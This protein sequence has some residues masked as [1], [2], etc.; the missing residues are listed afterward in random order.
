M[1]IRSDF[2]VLLN[3]LRT[4]IQQIALLQSTARQIFFNFFQNILILHRSRICVGFI[5]FDTGAKISI[6]VV[7]VFWGCRI[8]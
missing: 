7:V 8:N 1:S 4:M 6:S 3:P 5:C 2:S